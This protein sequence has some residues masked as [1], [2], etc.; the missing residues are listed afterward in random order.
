MT[1]YFKCTLLSDIVLTS[2]SAS[3]GFHKSL[4][5]IP[6][7]KFS[8]IVASQLYDTNNTL[9]TLDLFHNGNVRFGNAQIAINEQPSYAVPFSWYRDKLKRQNNIFLHH[10]I[11]AVI[12]EQHATNDWQ[13]KQERAGYINQNGDLKADLE[14]EFSIKSAYDYD[15]RK[16]LDEN[17]YGYH[18]LKVGS[19]FLFTVA[20]SGNNNY[21]GLLIKALS[22]KKR[23]G[24]SRTAE[25]GLVEITQCSAPF[26]EL[27]HG[28]TNENYQLIYASSDWCFYDEYGFPTTD[29]NAKDLHIPNGKIDWEKS[30]V[31]YR[32]YQSYNSRRLQTNEDRMVFQK[33]S[34]IAVQTN[35]TIDCQNI[36]YWVGSL[37]NEGFGKIIFNPPFLQNK[38]ETLPLPKEYK[39]SKTL[40]RHFVEKGQSDSQ[41][42]NLINQRAGLLEKDN[43]IEE[44]VNKFFN[45]NQKR[46]S[47]VS[48]SQWG[49]IRGIAKSTSN[50][51][52]FVELLF[53]E[54]KGFL[55]RGVA[56]KLWEGKVD[57]LQS[58]IE[59][60]NNETQNDKDKYY[61]NSQAMLIKLAS[62][63]QKA[64]YS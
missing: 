10:K 8:G 59:K 49:A 51:N 37:N 50:T 17:M 54:E 45:Q 5:F 21:D 46:L 58:F 47:G 30:Q 57:L 64:Q 52:T 40:K 35:E 3:E 2:R 53:N 32:K 34:V 11:D 31:R 16:S 12:R 18:A 23:I 48:K 25:Y 62:K 61:E 33:G 7:S 29:I 9:Q 28:T 4:T 6:G 13:L 36:P 60:R 38:D 55:K 15:K 24:R 26:S 22:G 63:M 1:L 42:L 39:I 19:E 43:A 27:Q 41:V 14:Q 56:A 20:I 44:M